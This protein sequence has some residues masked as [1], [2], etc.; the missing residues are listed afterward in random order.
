MGQVHAIRR[1]AKQCKL[2]PLYTV[3]SLYNS[4]GREYHDRPDLLFLEDSIR[5]GDV[6]WVAIRDLDRLIRHDE[7]RAHLY[8]ILRRT[9]TALYIASYGR[10]VDLEREKFSLQ[11]LGAATEHELDM[12]RSRTQSAVLR[13]YVGQGK[14]RTGAPRFGFYRD[15]QSGLWVKDPEQ[16]PVRRWIHMRFHELG[17]E[18]SLERL[19]KELVETWGPEWEF[20]PSYLSR[21]LRDPIDVTG[22][23]TTRVGR[24]RVTTIPVELGDDAVP[25]DVFQANNERLDQHR[26]PNSRLPIGFYCLNGIPVIH[27]ACADQEVRES[28]SGRMVQPRLRGRSYGDQEFVPRY[29]HLPGVPPGCHRYA[30]DAD[31]I[32]PAVIREVLRLAGSRT[33]QEEWRRAPRVEVAPDRPLINREGR[34][35]IEA[36]IRILETRKEALERELVQ[37]T[38]DGEDV[39]IEDAKLLIGPIQREIQRLQRRLAVATELPP[40][41][42]AAGLVRDPI[43][44]SLAHASETKAEDEAELLA[45]LKQLLTEQRPDDPEHLRRRAAVLEASLS[46]II[47]HDVEG[48]IALELQG[49]LVPPGAQLV[50]PIGPLES[51]RT[52]LEAHLRQGENHVGADDAGGANSTSAASDIPLTAA[53]HS[54]GNDIFDWLT[55]PPAEQVLDYQEVEALFFS[56]EQR[57]FS[58]ERKRVTM[59][60]LRIER[61]A[62]I[63]A[64]WEPAWVSP[65]IE[66]RAMTRAR[67]RDAIGLE[68]CLDALRRVA[69]ELGEGEPLTIPTYIARS[70]GRKDL[71]SHPVLQ[72]W[73]RRLG[74]SWPELT[75]LALHG[76][77]AGIVDNDPDAERPLSTVARDFGKDRLVLAKAAREG[78]LRA[79]KLRDR[80]YAR[81]EAIRD[82]LKRRGRGTPGSDVT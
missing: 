50:R 30:I 19:A 56:P 21:I 40:R 34:Q 17:P 39:T 53:S 10:A 45:V 67:R 37:R 24:L 22:E 61:R 36:N 60:R 1:L 9:R 16:Y 49:P 64:G 63:A 18:A 69:G 7:T 42:E 33:L 54:Q 44:R 6:E 77:A 79:R 81:P 31:V 68:P 57:I 2:R 80:W 46:A 38:L 14:G 12:I 72:R 5:Q 27:A 78:R 82:Y 4:A 70:T 74:L 66:V 20:S 15:P 58:S 62:A 35:R 11:V 55:P 23:R 13:R 75:N 26:G 73:C 47:V 28:G 43:L 8:N 59:E 71:P 41:P 3:A 51:A 76:S 65:P 52:I 48:G 29:K 25:A 32:E